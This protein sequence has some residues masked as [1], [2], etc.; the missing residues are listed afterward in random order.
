MSEHSQFT[1]GLAIQ[2][3]DMKTIFTGSQCGFQ[4]LVFLR[5]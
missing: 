3:R 1:N 5:V 4:V 2:C